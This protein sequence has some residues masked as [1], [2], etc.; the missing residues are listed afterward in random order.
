MCCYS[1]TMISVLTQQT[2]DQYSLFL[3]NDWKTKHILLSFTTVLSIRDFLFDFLGEL[4][5]S[6]S[7]NES[8]LCLQI[9]IFR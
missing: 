7:L 3:F 1:A 6:T 9:R 4:G 8:H 2:A 5:I